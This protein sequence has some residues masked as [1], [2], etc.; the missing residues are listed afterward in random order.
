MDGVSVA[1]KKNSK[2]KMSESVLVFAS[3]GSPT[4]GVYKNFHFYNIESKF[5]LM[6]RSYIGFIIFASEEFV[7]RVEGKL[8]VVY[9]FGPKCWD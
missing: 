6:F 2:P 9:L 5:V 3:L 8:E 7:H 1:K 4:D